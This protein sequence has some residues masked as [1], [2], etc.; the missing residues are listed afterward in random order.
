[1][2]LS[3][4]G[5]HVR[6]GRA[7]LASVVGVDATVSPLCACIGR[8]S[9]PWNLTTTSPA[10]SNPNQ[11]RVGGSASPKGHTHTHTTG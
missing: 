9:L 5:S 11:E 6:L 3:P 2:L 8:V 4:F 7:A 1:M 10:P